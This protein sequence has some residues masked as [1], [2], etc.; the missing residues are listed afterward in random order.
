MAGNLIHRLSLIGYWSNPTQV[1]ERAG[2]RPDPRHVMAEWST[3]DRRD[4]LAHLRRGKLF[5]TFLG[6]SACRICAQ[7]LGSGELTD[8][9]WAWPEGLDHYVEAH[10]TRLPEAFITAARHSDREIPPWVASLGPDLWISCG[11]SMAPIDTTSERTWIV[12][13]C[14]WLD[15]AAANTPACPA[16]DALTLDEARELSCKLSHP[17]WTCA[18]DDAWGRWV[19]TIGEG[20]KTDTTRIYL[21]KSSAAVL[22]RRLLNLRV[23]DVTRILDLES[24]EAIAAEYDGA[25]GAARVICASSEAWLV[26]VKTLKSHWPTEAQIEK[27][28]QAEPQFGWTMFYP[29]GGKVFIASAADEPAWRWLLTCQRE[30]GEQSLNMQ[31]RI[32]ARWWAA[33]RHRV[34]R[35]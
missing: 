6:S 33:I 5:R 1:P 15:W 13:E 28:L 3:L 20:D 18:V 23:P 29:D 31:P 17:A 30:S 10:G 19:V 11:D 26:W 2:G 32:L 12:D 9:V 35:S 25:W 4:V 16:S 8:G 22:E 34:W 14:T 24:A 21:Q 7:V 27:I